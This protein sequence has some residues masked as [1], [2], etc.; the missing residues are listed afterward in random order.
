MTDQRSDLLKPEYDVFV[1]VAGFSRHHRN[2]MRNVLLNAFQLIHRHQQVVWD[3]AL[4]WHR[5]VVKVQPS[6][7]SFQQ[8]P[9]EFV[10]E[11]LC[12]RRLDS[13]EPLQTAFQVFCSR[14]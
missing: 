14:M 3:D 13:F 2:N 10:T 7:R 5:V 8:I 1:V 9:V 12:R 4:D 6:N 11:L